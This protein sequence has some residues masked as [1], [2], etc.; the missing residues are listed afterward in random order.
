M[1]QYGLTIHWKV[2]W[3]QSTLDRAVLCIAH[4]F[5]FFTYLG[6]ISKPFNS[7]VS[8]ERAPGDFAYSVPAGLIWSP[9]LCI[10]E[11]LRVVLVWLL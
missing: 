6:E 1:T 9:S 11:Q 7:H 10:S 2:V 8:V 3:E 5:V 4:A